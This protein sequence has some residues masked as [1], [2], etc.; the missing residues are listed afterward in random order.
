MHECPFQR[1]G[2]RHPD[3]ANTIVRLTELFAAR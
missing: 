3:A 2:M 1:T